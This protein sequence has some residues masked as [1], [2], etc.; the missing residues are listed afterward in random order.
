VNRG[1]ICQYTSTHH[2]NPLDQHDLARTRAA[3]A[4]SER[5]MYEHAIVTFAINEKSR[6]VD[7]LALA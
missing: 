3:V 4:A 6:Q 7:D 5:R 1:N 2:L